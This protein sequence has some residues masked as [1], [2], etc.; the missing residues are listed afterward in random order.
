MISAA[1]APIF[2][3]LSLCLQL[4]ILMHSDRH[5]SY[6]SKASLN[7]SVPFMDCQMAFFSVRQADN[8]WVTVVL[9][10]KTVC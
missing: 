9:I 3:C 10:A 4:Q 5:K 7:I 8:H 2:C 6:C 1:I